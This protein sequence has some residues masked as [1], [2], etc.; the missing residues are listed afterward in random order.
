MECPEVRQ[1][2]LPVHNNELTS[3]STTASIPAPASG[4]SSDSAAAYRSAGNP[5]A[6]DRRGIGGP[7]GQ[8]TGPAARI[9]EEDNG[10]AGHLWRVDGGR[11]GD[12]RPPRRQD[13][14]ADSQSRGLAAPQGRFETHPGHAEE[15]AL[16]TRGLRAQAP[17]QRT[18]AGKMGTRTRETQ[19]SGRRTGAAGA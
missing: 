17:H 14:I 10:K 3:T 5:H 9:T 7:G 12:E 4:S 2:H 16:F 13:H 8:A 11:G 15:A 19:S 1:I 18:N 6:P